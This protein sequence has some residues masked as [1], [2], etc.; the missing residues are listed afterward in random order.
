MSV[1]SL[2]RIVMKCAATISMLVAVGLSLFCV[3]AA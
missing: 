1:Y 3:D 2:A